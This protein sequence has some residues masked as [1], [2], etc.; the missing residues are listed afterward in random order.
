[1]APRHISLLTEI[2]A[3]FRIPLFNAL[4]AEPHVTLDVLFLAERDP[5]RP[6]PLYADEFRFTWTILDRYEV[7]PGGRWIVLNRG[8]LSRLLRTRPS[9]VVIGGWNQPAFWVAALYC[10]LSR[11]PLVAWVESTERDLRHGSVL[12]ELPKRVLIRACRAFLVPGRASAEYLAKLGVDRRLVHIAPN[13]VDTH[14]FGDLVERARLRRTNLRSKLGLDRCAFLYV[15]RLDA[16]KGVDVLLDAARQVDA[17]FIIVGSGSCEEALRRSAPSNVRFIGRLERDAL[18]P[19]YAAA[20]A[21]VLPSRSE[22]WGM[23]LNE[24]LT[25]GLPLVAT[26]APGAAHDLIEDGVNG[27]R[28]AAGDPHA[29]AGALRRVAQDD[30]FRRAASLRSHEL[31]ASFTPAAWAR[32]VAAVCASVGRGVH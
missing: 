8:V 26:V 25:A 17:Q 24:A 19:W 23:V 20:D 5:K 30:E 9:M 21:F 22:Q 31:A 12:T 2:P 11:T 28:V 3:P 1:V 4:S 15:G 29:L 16:E 18:V 7:Q 6:Y 13:A 10:R 14:I 27:F 32:S